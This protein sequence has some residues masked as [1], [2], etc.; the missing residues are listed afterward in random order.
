MAPKKDFTFV[1][2]PA[3]TRITKVSAPRPVAFVDEKD[4]KAARRV[5]RSRAAAHSHHSGE[6]KAKSSKFKVQPHHNLERLEKAAEKRSLPS[7]PTPDPTPPLQRG[8]TSGSSA[9]IETALMR[10]PSPRGLSAGRVDPFDSY[11]VPS[12]PWFPMAIDYCRLLSCIFTGQ[13]LHSG[14]VYNFL[15]P[16]SWPA[17]SISPKEGDAWLK[18][19]FQ[20]AMT[21]PAFFYTNIFTATGPM[22]RQGLLHPYL[23]LYIRDRTIVAVNEALKDPSRAL[24]TATILAVGRIALHECFYG[25][26]QAS[27]NIHRPAQ[28]RMIAKRGGLRAMDLPPISYHLLCWADRVMASHLG[29]TLCFTPAAD[30]RIRLFEGGVKDSKSND[31]PIQSEELLDIYGPEKT[32][33]DG[34]GL[35]ASQTSD[36]DNAEIRDPRL[37]AIEQAKEQCGSASLSL[38]PDT[39]QE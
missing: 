39:S 22:V 21:E 29:T 31:G 11:P 1:H 15:T 12:Q 20:L 13:G 36:S 38:R 30:E 5:V 23:E 27:N 33:N 10:S 28:A 26:K 25:N 3:P 6:R 16:Q 18:W 19:T 4:T 37:S 34:K 2:E 24:S 35:Q 9:S 7:Y 8:S 14:I 32:Q 17:M